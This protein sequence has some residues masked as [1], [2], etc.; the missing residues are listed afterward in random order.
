MDEATPIRPTGWDVC[1]GVVLGH[2]SPPEAPPRTLHSGPRGGGTEPRPASPLAALEEA[3]LPALRRP[4]CLVSFSG[5]LDSSL[6]LAVAVR[7]ARRAGLPEPVPATWRFTGAPRADESDWQDRVVA[8]LGCPSWQVLRADDD[9]D[10][11]GPVARRMLLRHGLLHPANAHLHLP[12]VELASGGSVLTGAGGDQVLAGWRRRHPGP[13]YRRLRA[14]AHRWCRDARRRPS[15]RDLFPW[16]RPEVAAEVHRLLRAERRAEPRRLAERIAW[17]T[18]RRDLRLTRAGLAGIAADH[19]VRLVHPLLDDHFLAALSDRAGRRR[20][21]SRADLLA[22][23]VGDALPGVVTAPRRK[24]R[25]LEVFLRT[26]TRRF[27]RAWDGR[28]VDTDLVDVEAL[29]R[30]W[31][32]WP[33]PG[34]TAALVQQAWLAT[35]VRP[36]TP[37]THHGRRPSDPETTEARS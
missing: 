26:P 23:I 10:L 4:P 28:G 17:H 9:L 29:R 24:A 12:V 11:T 20:C 2:V 31:S 37:V 25:F 5:G 18:G 8:A 30:A 3:V 7:V 21:P 16:L 6:V 22:E 13:P 32:R 36:V 19:R 1:S 34:G 14:A 15:P 27:V 35:T 33:I